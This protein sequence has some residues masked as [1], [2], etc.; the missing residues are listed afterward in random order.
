[1]LRSVIV[2]TFVAACAASM[3]RPPMGPL[4]EEAFVRIGGIDQ[5]ITIRGEDRANPVLLFV[6]GGPGDPQSSLPSL[7]KVYERDF[8]IVQWDQPGA[9]KTYGKN[10]TVAPIPARVIADGIELTRYLEQHLGKRKLIVVGHS[11]GSLL[12]NGMAQRAPDL[13]TALVG[14]VGTGEGHDPRNGARAGAEAKAVDEPRLLRQRVAGRRARIARSTLDHVRDQRIGRLLDVEPAGVDHREPER[15]GLAAQVRGPG[16]HVLGGELGLA[17]RDQ[18]R[19][20][21]VARAMD[22]HNAATDTGFRERT[23][24]ECRPGLTVEHGNVGG[25]ASEALDPL[26][27]RLLLPVGWHLVGLWHADRVE[28]RARYAREVALGEPGHD[29]RLAGARCT[30]DN[31]DSRG[32]GTFYPR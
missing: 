3:H 18:A 31:D 6:H 30:G 5:W 10:P 22:D 20:A 2:V 23:Q 9:G 12:A 24:R 14:A 11:W 1:M 13:Y 27:R 16:V 28:E 25:R 17:A 15:V 4:Q 19:L 21:H 7:Y 26:V 32:H 8:T 29:G